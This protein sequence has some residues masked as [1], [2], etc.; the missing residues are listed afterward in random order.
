M[1]DASSVN[2]SR[3]ECKLCAAEHNLQS[4]TECANLLKRSIKISF[5]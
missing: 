2:H 1:N 3:W 5:N 4:Q